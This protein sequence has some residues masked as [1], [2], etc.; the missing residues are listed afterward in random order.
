MAKSLPPVW[1]FALIAT[2]LKER[3]LP[4]FIPPEFG[5]PL[6][7]AHPSEEM[8]AALRLRRSTSA[9]LMTAPGPDA[10]AL[11]SILAIAARVPDHRRVCPFRFLVFEGEGRAAAGDIIARIFAAEDHF[12]GESRIEAERR[13]F[14]RAPVVV[15]V[16]S[17]VDRT[18]KTPEWEQILTAGAVCQNLLLAASAHGFAAQ[19]VTEWLAYDRDLLDGFGL[20]PDEKIAGFV[21]LGTAREPPRER[22]RPDLAALVSYFGARPEQM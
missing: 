8:I 4:S 6:P 14:L 12:A 7:A 1:T 15:G 5:A 17:A 22:Q 3:L 13:R 10:A 20:K 9:D 11:G 2:R 16:V 19:W 18:H 21:Y